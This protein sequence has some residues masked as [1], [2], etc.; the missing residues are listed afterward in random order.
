MAMETVVR[1]RSKN[2]ALGSTVYSKSRDY[3]SPSIAFVGMFAFAFLP[4]YYSHLPSF[5][6]FYLSVCKVSISGFH[7]PGRKLLNYWATVIRF[8]QFHI[9]NF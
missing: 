5:L 4:F 1:W 6:T 7:H 2:V 9:A 3:V 8:L